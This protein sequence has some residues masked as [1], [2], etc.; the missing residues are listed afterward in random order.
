[1]PRLSFTDL[2]R[3]ISKGDIAPVYLIYGDEKFLVDESVLKICSVYAA[4]T[5]GE[6]YRYS[7]KDASIVDVIADLNTLPMWGRGKAVVVSEIEALKSEALH[8]IEKYLDSP[9]PTSVLVLV[10]EKCDGRT[11]LYKKVLKSGVVIE[12]KKIYDDAVPSWINA[13]CKRRGVSIS[14]DAANYMAELI[15]ADLALLSDAIEKTILYVHDRKMINVDDVDAVISDI[16]RH[17][18]FHLTSA[19]GKRD[20]VLAK[21]ELTNLMRQSELP[22]I[23]IAMLARYIRLLLKTREAIER[24]RFLSPRQIATEIGVNPYFASEYIDGAKRFT[25]EELK[26]RLSL[27]HEADVVLKSGARPKKIVLSKLVSDIILGAR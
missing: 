25:K 3:S 17:S 13:E 18:I 16:S 5:K 2:K 27:I 24:D 6:I 4:E 15:G 12:A 26:R 21:K 11:S 20:L 14:Q 23:I 8:E 1:M 9:S 10:G 19:I 22:V 7:A